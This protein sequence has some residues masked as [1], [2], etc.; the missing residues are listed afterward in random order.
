MPEAL[1]ALSDDRLIADILATTRVSLDTAWLAVGL[2]RR[3]YA[4][5]PQAHAKVVVVLQQGPAAIDEL[6][7]ATGL[8]RRT[9]QAGLQFL[10]SQG[11]VRRVQASPSSRAF[12]YWLKAVA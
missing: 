10:M 3:R 4:R 1:M 12:E 7:A 11:L 5:G 8:T 9:A 2:A 6:V